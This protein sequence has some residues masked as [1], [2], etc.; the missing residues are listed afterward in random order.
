MKFIHLAD[1]H[2]GAAPEAGQCTG[3]TRR[4]EIWETFREVIADAG[5]QKADLLLIAGDL[6]HTQPTT[7]ELREIN[8]LFSQIPNTRVVL[9]AGNHDCLSGSLLAE[10]PWNRNVAGL[11]SPV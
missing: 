1:V 4:R 6:F 3:E 10:F 5:R 8:Y 9:M 11:F 7:E 2:L